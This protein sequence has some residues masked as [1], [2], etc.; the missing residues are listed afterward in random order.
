MGGGSWTKTSFAS[1]STAS[2]KKMNADST[3]DYSGMST[4]QIFRQTGLHKDLNPYNVIRECRDSKEHPNTIPVIIGI[5][6]TGSMGPAAREVASKLNPIITDIMEKQTDVEFMIMGIGDLYYDQV[7]IQASQF[8]SD[9]RIARQLDQIYFEGGGGGN[10]AESYTAA[11]YFGLHNTDLD[12]VKRGKRGII[13]TIGDEPLNE[14]LPV[15]VLNGVLGSHEQ[16]NIDSQTLFEKASEKFDIYHI[17]VNHDNGSKSRE[18]SAKTRFGNIIG[19]QNVMVTD[20]DGL[21]KLIS[22]IVAD[23]A[24]KNNE[25]N[26]V[27]VENDEEETEVKK[28][29]HGNGPVVL[30][31]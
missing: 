20:L 18:K 30:S 29:N 22:S 27:I 5:D 4:N 9:V 12:C 3:I 6:V 28:D 13:I 7:P 19:N 17:H 14:D 8:E 10:D 23:K 2:G 1:Y 31:W 11:W 26:N 24:N 15:R 25:K 21:T 16:A